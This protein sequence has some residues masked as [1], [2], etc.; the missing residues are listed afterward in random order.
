MKTI[1][2]EKNQKSTPYFKNNNTLIYQ[3][4]ILKTNQVPK[5]SIDLIIDSPPYS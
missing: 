1:I 3:S 4:D 2:G 5:S